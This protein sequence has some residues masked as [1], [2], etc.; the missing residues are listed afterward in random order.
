M[1][2]CWDDEIKKGRGRFEIIDSVQ[3]IIKNGE[4]FVVMEFENGESIMCIKGR[5]PM[6]SEPMMVWNDVEV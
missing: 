6:F 2:M 1:R 3:N 4:R 5:A